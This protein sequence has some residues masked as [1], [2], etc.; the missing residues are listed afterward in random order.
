[1]VTWGIFFHSRAGLARV[2]PKALYCFTSIP[3][4]RWS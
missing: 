2:L 4:C 3:D 1:M